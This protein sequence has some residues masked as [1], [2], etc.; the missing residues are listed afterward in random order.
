MQENTQQI[1]NNQTGLNGDLIC[2][3]HG[4]SVIAVCLSTV[5]TNLSHCCLI[6]IKTKHMQCGVDKIVAF[7]DF[8]CMISIVPLNKEEVER[9][10]QT[11]DNYIKDKENKEQLENEKYDIISSL[12]MLKDINDFKDIDN[13]VTIKKLYNIEFDSTINKLVITHKLYSD[14]EELQRCLDT[15]KNGIT[16]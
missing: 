11:L 6:C 13:I 14:N 15:L 16:N 3:E 12:N 5:C 9:I 8:H 4:R 7:C 1:Q 2:K 10:K